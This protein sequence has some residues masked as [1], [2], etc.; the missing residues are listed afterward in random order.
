[1]KQITPLSGIVTGWSCVLTVAAL[2]CLIALQPALADDLKVLRLG[3]GGA[4]GTYFPIGTLVATGLTGAVG[5]TNCAGALECGVKDVLAVAQVSNGSVTNLESLQAGTIEVAFAQSNVVD[6]AYNGRAP[7]RGRTPANDLRA[8]A[9]LYSESLH[10][11]VRADAGV[12]TIA[13]L[14]GKRVSLDE[15]G[16]GTLD[17]VREVLRGYGLSEAD[18]AA[19]YVKPDLAI[20]RMEAGQLDGFFIVAGAPISALLKA[21]SQMPLALLPIDGAAA[22]TLL[23]RMPFYSRTVIPAGAYPGIPEVATIAVGAQ[24]IVR[25]DL[26]EQLAYE[27]TRALWSDRTR[28][29]LSDGHPKGREITIENA[30]RGLSIPLHPG[31]ERFY[32]EVG[33]LG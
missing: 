4:G 23:K 21:S 10:A 18:L 29:V 5:A 30:L 25:A 20:Q 11:V 33:V 32:R 15:R 22:D 28:K 7:F 27:I 12:S 14:R 31:A 2:L 13:R 17:D 3:T 24:V 26:D 8:I 19:E 1:M 9:T 6:A 16:S